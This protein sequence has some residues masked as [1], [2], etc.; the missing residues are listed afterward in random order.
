MLQSHT[1]RRSL[2]ESLG[3][4]VFSEEELENISLGLTRGIKCCLG[5]GGRYVQGL[6]PV[7]SFKLRSHQSEQRRPPPNQTQTTSISGPKYDKYLMFCKYLRRSEQSCHILSTF[8][9]LNCDRRHSF[10]LEE[11]R[12]SNNKMNLLLDIILS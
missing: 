3:R 10:A 6:A 8:P 11:E 4:P 5:S 2:P 9:S 1:P 7:M 12:P